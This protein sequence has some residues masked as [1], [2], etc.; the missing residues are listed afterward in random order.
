MARDL[1]EECSSMN[2]TSSK[3]STCHQPPLALKQQSPEQPITWNRESA[4]AAPSPAQE[5]DSIHALQ[6]TS[7]SLSEP[8]SN[9]LSQDTASSISSLVT[10]SSLPSMESLTSVQSSKIKQPE[11]TAWST[12]SHRKSMLSDNPQDQGNCHFPFL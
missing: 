8:E 1:D 5:K 9:Q 7:A 2:L 12:T 6:G 11:V 4:A 3:Q 10:A